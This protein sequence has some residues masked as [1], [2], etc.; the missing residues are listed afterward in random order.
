MAPTNA[1]TTAVLSP[2]RRICVAIASAANPN[3]MPS[4]TYSRKNA[5]S[6]PR[7][8]LSRLGSRT[9][10]PSGSVGVE[11]NALADGAEKFV[12]NGAGSTRQL[13]DRELR[14][15]ELRV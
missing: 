10:G 1:P 2:L 4:V 14:T 9:S 12:G 13:F 3:G 11:R 6:R 8:L 7:R 5:A 15:P